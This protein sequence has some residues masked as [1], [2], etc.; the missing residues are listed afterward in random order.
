MTK[1]IEL[2]NHA[3]NKTQEHKKKAY[4]LKKLSLWIPVL[5]II[6][7]LIFFIIQIVLEYIHKEEKPNLTISNGVLWLLSEIFSVKITI[8]LVEGYTLNMELSVRYR[9][10]TKKIRLNM[11]RSPQDDLEI[12]DYGDLERGIGINNNT[13]TKDIIVK[14]IKELD[15]KSELLLK[16]VF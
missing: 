16:P 8:S 3:Q 15:I 2:L 4:K 6:V 7:P 10:V 9:E 13:N 5:S 1:N 12:S 11:P 14:E